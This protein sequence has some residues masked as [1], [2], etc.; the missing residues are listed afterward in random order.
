VFSWAYIFQRGPYPVQLTSFLES[1]TSL[2]SFENNRHIDLQLCSL[3]G[4]NKNQ[5]QDFSSLLVPVDLNWEDVTRIEECGGARTGSDLEREGG[6]TEEGE[7]DGVKDG[8]NLLL[9][10]GEDV[11][12]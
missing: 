7:L 5:V 9:L 10:G 3:V 8:L 11:F 12:S 1:R 6:G 4:P 2:F